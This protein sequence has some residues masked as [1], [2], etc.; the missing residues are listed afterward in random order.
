MA[1]AAY[2]RVYVL[3][4]RSRDHQQHIP[5]A[6]SALLTAGEH[7]VW[8]E[9][10]RDDAFLLE[11]G[12]RRYVCPRWPR[13][14]MLEGLLAFRNAFAGAAASALVPERVAKRAGR[15]LEAIQQRHPTARSYILTS[16][17]HVPLRWF[18]AFDPSQRELVEADSGLS[19]RYRTPLADAIARLDHTV[20]VLD[21]VGFDDV[22]VDP[23][24]D[25]HRW[26]R[27]FPSEAVVELDYAS[28][29]GLFNDA[30]IALDETAAVLAASIS[31][32]ESG[33]L[34][35][36]AEHYAEAASRWAHVQAIAYAS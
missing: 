22:I 28:V 17:F 18:A 31:A 9:S 23:V 3:D 6:P 35:R 36:A 34:D 11:R 24:R 4:D 33:D 13:L 15:E 16:A 30:E 29:A 2:L 32:L 21:E 10:A 26:L 14:R 27:R 19:I 1:S 7:I 20:E 25:L 12:G 8:H 5:A